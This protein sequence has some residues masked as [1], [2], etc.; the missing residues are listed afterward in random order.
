VGLVR[1]QHRRDVRR[2]DFLCAHEGFFGAGEVNLD[3]D[4]KIGAPL[5]PPIWG[6]S[7]DFLVSTDGGQSWQDSDIPASPGHYSFKPAP[8]ISAVAQVTAI[9]N[10]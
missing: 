9:P 6:Q 5:D 2:D 3:G 1:V 8:G 4:W 7:S 10:R